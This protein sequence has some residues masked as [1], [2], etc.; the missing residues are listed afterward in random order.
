MRE[1]LLSIDASWRLWFTR[2]FT[3]LFFL[4][5]LT[6]WSYYGLLCILP[7]TLGSVGMS[8]VIVSFILVEWGDY[9]MGILRENYERKVAEKTQQ[10]EY[11]RAVK[12]FESEKAKGSEGFRNPP[13]PPTP[14][15]P[16]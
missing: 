3:V 12:W 15:K 14:S 11:E 5:V 13:P 2:I 4:G 10:K 7:K 9:A 8:A 16:K 6:S 1:G